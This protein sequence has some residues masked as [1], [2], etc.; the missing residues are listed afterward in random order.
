MAKEIEVQVY[1]IDVEK[2]RKKLANLGAVFSAKGIQRRYTYKLPLS[3]IEQGFIGYIRIRHEIDGK[4]KL[5]IKR[6]KQSDKFTDEV[7]IISVS[8]LD[9]CFHWLN[10]MGLEL[11]SY[12]EQYRECYLLPGFKEITFDTMPALPTYME[13][14]AESVDHIHTLAEQLGIDESQ[15]R[16]Q[17]YANAYHEIYGIPIS[18]INEPYKHYEP[19]KATLTFAN[20]SQELGAFVTKNQEEFKELAHVHRSLKFNET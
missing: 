2:M 19:G 20:A 11:L 18:V 14:E 9:D 13:L 1:R 8:S 16:Y 17:T 10:S 5:V 3:I 4:V 12:A 6:R 15:F 7:E